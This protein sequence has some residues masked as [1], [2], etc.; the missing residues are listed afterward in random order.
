M[1][2]SNKKTLLIVD[3]FETIENQQEVLG[4]LNQLPFTTKGI[5]TSRE[6]VSGYCSI[7]L[8]SL[9]GRDS[10]RL[11]R[12]QAAEKKLQLTENQCNAIY[13]RFGGVPL[14]LV[15]AMGQLASRYPIETLLDESVTLSEDVAKFCF[16][17]SVKLLKK[18]TCI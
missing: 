6:R 18:K 12:Q 3:N 9:P 10:I 15:Y 11:I 13:Q 7:F 4:F 17:S 16:E 1:G 2:W 8:D 5:I 14:A